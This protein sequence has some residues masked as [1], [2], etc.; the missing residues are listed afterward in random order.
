MPTASRLKYR[1]EKAARE[2][3]PVPAIT[4]KPDTLPWPWALDDWLRLRGFPVPAHAVA[5]PA[6]AI[7]RHLR[8]EDSF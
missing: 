1:R 7:A 5:S 3:Q 2:A 6:V 8:F 4:V